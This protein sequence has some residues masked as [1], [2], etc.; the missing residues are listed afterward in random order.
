MANFSKVVTRDVDDKPTG[1]A[2]WNHPEYVGVWTDTMEDLFRSYDLDGIQWGAE[3]Q[4]PLMNVVSPWDNRPPT[5]FCEFCHARAKPTAWI[6][7]ARGPV[8]G[9]LGSRAGQAQMPSTADGV[10]ASY[11]TSLMR[12]PEILAWEYQYRLAR[13]EICAAMYKRVKSIKPS[14]GG[15]LACRPSAVEL[16]HGLSRGDELRGDGAAFG[17]HQADRLP[18]RARPAHS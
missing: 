3:R 5:C 1:T 11:L 18:L 14:A 13:E 9:V 15:R 7:I 10:F 4:G 8:S 12:Y 16:G 17:L 2:C 6:P